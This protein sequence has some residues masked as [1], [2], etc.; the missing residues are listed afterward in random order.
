MDTVKSLKGFKNGRSIADT[1]NYMENLVKAGVDMFDVDLGC[2][3]N[4]WLPHPPAG[5][6]A[7]CFLDVSKV[8]K[9][10]FAARG[11]KSNVGME[12]P[13]VAVGKLGYPD[14]A[15]QALRDGK[16]DMI[17]LC[18]PMP[19]GATRPTPVRWRTSVPASAARRAASTSSSRAAIPSA[20]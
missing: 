4:W 16:C 18:W 8:A 19:T 9:E 11:V 12:V 20:P 15:E 1:L 10:Y 17:M 6:P 5:M 2:Y 14:L 13:I 7:G 3:D